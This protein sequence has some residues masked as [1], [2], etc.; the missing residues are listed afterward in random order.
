MNGNTTAPTARTAL[1]IG[2]DT[3]AFLGVVRSLGRL[4][5]AVHVAPFDFSSVALQSRHV[6]AV[7]RLPHQFDPADW[8]TAVLALCEQIRPDFIVPCDDRSILPLHEFRDRVAH[9]PLAMPGALAY[10]AFFDKGNTRKLAAHCAVPVPPGRLLAGGETAEKLVA[11]YGLPLFIKPRNSYLLRALESRRNVITCHSV[12]AVQAALAGLQLPSEF[13]VE[14]CCTGIGVG[15]SVLAQDGVISQTFQHRRVREP[16]GGGGS[17]YRLSETPDPDLLAMTEALCKSSRLQGVAMFEFKVDDATGHK[18]LLEVNARFWGSLPL[19]MAAGVDFPALLFQQALGAAPAPRVIYRVPCYAR[20]LL[21]DLYAVLGHIDATRGAGALAHTA[22]VLRWLAS[23]GRL[24]IGRESLDTLARD[25]PRPGWLEI[26]AITL[27]VAERLTRLLPGLRG[28]GTQQPA[29]AVQAAFRAAAQARRPV[30]IVVACY[31]NICRSPYAAVQLARALQSCPHG[32]V[33][34]GVALAARAGRASPV[35]AV[36]AAARAGV[37]LANHRSRFA[38]D[39]L[40]QAADLVLVFD[41]KNLALI[42]A[43]G[44]PLQRPALRLRELLGEEAGSC[45]IDDPYGH[46]DASF[47]RCY[48]LIDRAIAVLRTL[49]PVRESAA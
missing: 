15:V 21:A 32:V 17:S 30:Q 48:Q 9:L 8:I 44:L 5:V 25:D 7:H 13:L 2:S 22:V 24:A 28:R 41:S 3:R 4:G 46:D 39:A 23:F 27:K 10:A 38:D 14:G 43:R 19:A 18:A 16:V 12:A 40:L 20:N 31:G 49:L 45:D 37:D 6:Q 35:A 36:A 42:E 47:D 29:L 1:V 33:V 34:T 11:D 26:K